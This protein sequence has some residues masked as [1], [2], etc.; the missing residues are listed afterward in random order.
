[1]KR[2]FSLLIFILLGQNVTSQICTQRM[3]RNLEAFAK[4]CGYVRYFY[5]GDEAAKLNWEQFIHYG[6]KQVELLKNDS[7]LLNKLNQLLYPVAPALIIDYK[8]KT[9]VYKEK[10][11]NNA[12]MVPVYWQHYGYG[13]STIQPS[14]YESIRINRDS[15]GKDLFE[16]K[17]Q[18]S[19]V[20]I[21]DITSD[22]RLFM[23]LLLM[24]DSIQTHPASDKVLL[25]QLQE[26]ATREWPEHPSGDNKY[27][28]ITSMIILWNIM[29]HFNPHWE[30]ASIKPGAMLRE[31]ITDC[32]TSN[33]SL[34]FYDVLRKTT[35]RLNDA[36]TGFFVD[37]NDSAIKKFVLPVRFAEAGNRIVVDY[38][39]D[40]SLAA[41]FKPGDIVETINGKN[42]LQYK[43]EYETKVS[44]S[45]QFKSWY[46]TAYMLYDTDTRVT[47]QVK[48]KPEVTFE[49]K[50]P[51]SQFNTRQR[52]QK[53]TGWLE[54]G[55]FYLD[56]DNATDSVY[57][58]YLPEI[59]NAKVLICDLRTYPK[60]NFVFSLLKS[61]M[62]KTPDRDWLFVPKIIY[63]DF[64]KVT[65][66]NSHW[67]FKPDTVNQINAKVFLLT[68]PRSIS[69]AESVIG[70]FK[71]YQLATIIGQPT[72]GANGN[73]AQVKLPGNYSVGWTEM[74]VKGQD[75]SRVFG[76]GF[77]PDILVNL[78][79]KGILENKD[80]VLDIALRKSRVY[81]KKNTK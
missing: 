48:G 55:I 29:K 20:I 67:R 58:L 62:R 57:Q 70:H 75:G 68:S 36:H 21:K 35:A 19:D 37:F 33:S 77:A 79:R 6:V 51:I 39:N 8:T 5:P 28:R 65:Y 52:K 30:F 60:G 16:N 7:E 78:T 25:R 34:S 27:I 80:E 32:F 64:N 54:P 18:W 59:L 10:R 81:L 56:I 3:L 24:G 72:A 71:H 47:V 46:A 9:S 13:H 2:L 40:T 17:P 76:V 61:L 44:G 11:V 14:P 22:I 1:M 12:G 69:Y 45:P 4:V 43:K 53:K 73:V 63:P 31:G 42:I 38:T 26:E 74:L 49:K 23:P 66:N 41:Y 50:T 15:L